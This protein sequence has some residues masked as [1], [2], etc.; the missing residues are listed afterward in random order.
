MIKEKQ[1]TV[2]P[3]DYVFVIGQTGE[4]KSCYLPTSLTNPAEVCKILNIYGIDDVEDIS[5]TR[6]LH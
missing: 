2:E 3:T 5:N 6:V 1:T 4:L